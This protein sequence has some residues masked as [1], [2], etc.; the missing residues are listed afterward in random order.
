MYYNENKI[1][2][3]IVIVN[4]V[5]D[6][7]NILRNNTGMFSDHCRNIINF[8]KYGNRN[9]IDLDIVI[10]MKNKDRIAY[11][12]V[13]TI[14]EFVFGVSGHQNDV[15][16]RIWERVYYIENNA[17]KFE[18][19]VVI[20]D[21]DIINDGNLSMSNFIYMNRGQIKDLGDRNENGD[22]INV[23]QLNE[24]ETNLTKYVK[25]EIGKIN[26]NINNYSRFI[27][28]FIQLYN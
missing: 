24:M 8:H 19:N 4:A 23:K 6:T 2:K 28:C 5:S 3:N 10:T 1:D 25:A 22:V 14:Y 27:S 7:L 26:T 17:V 13:S 16:L 12:P 15:D 18:A 20:N 9:I 21:R 11:D